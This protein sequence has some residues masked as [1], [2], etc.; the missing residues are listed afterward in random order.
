MWDDREQQGLLGKLGEMQRGWPEHLEREVQLRVPLRVC[1][2]QLLHGLAELSAGQEE[3]ARHEADEE[4]PHIKEQER[5][6]HAAQPC[7][8][9]QEW[10]HV[11]QHV[12]REAKE[13]LN[14]NVCRRRGDRSQLAHAEARR[15]S[16]F[17]E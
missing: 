4:R 16:R 12:K 5:L 10:Q 1:V 2:L 3:A 9:E 13:A 14:Q 17:A 6:Q 8:R 7:K 15:A 11:E